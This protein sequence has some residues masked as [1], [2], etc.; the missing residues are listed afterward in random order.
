MTPRPGDF[1]RRSRTDDAPVKVLVRLRSGPPDEACLT[2]LRGL[3]LTVDRVIDGTV[4]GEA[5]PGARRRLAADP[6]VAEVEV[7]RRLSPHEE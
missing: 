6:E 3:G 5:A 4:V 1:L 2:R 7:S